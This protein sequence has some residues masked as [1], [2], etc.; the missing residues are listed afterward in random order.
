[1]GD[2]VKQTLQA[3]TQLPIEEITTTED[4]PLA[5]Q[6][7]TFNDFDILVTTH[8]SHL[9]NGIFTMHPYTKAVIE[10]VPFVYDSIYYKNYIM[11]LGFADYVLSTGHLTPKPAISATVNSQKTMIGN[12]TTFLCFST[13]FRFCQQRL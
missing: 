12:G 13:V 6:I 7:K 4:Q 3:F 11:D 1:M 2:Q 5:E 9:T 10:I 8:G